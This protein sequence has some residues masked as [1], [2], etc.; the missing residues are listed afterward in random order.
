MI[1]TIRRM[2][3]LA[4][5]TVIAACAASAPP[6]DEAASAIRQATQ[7]WM[8]AFKAGDPVAAAS[9]MTEN[10]TLVPPNAPV[11]RGRQA[12]E[13]WGRNMMG[14][15]TVEQGTVT[16]DEVRVAGDWA[17]SHG[18]WAMAGTANGMAFA[19][20]TRYVVIWERQ[21][22]GSWKAAHDVWNSGMALPEQ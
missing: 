13:E 3:S 4:L 2:S 5:V 9:F 6:N 20:T 21:A 15:M 18:T 14:M 22:D 12:I 1:R 17:V 11:V 16:V 8:E 10:A 19:D 7:D